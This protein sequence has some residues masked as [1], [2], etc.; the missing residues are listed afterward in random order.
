M[1]LC[2]AIAGNTCRYDRLKVVFV[3]RYFSFKKQ[4][5]GIKLS[6]IELLTFEYVP[7]LHS[8]AKKYEKFSSFGNA[9]GQEKN[10]KKMDQA[11]NMGIGGG[12][13]AGNSLIL[14]QKPVGIS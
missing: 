1:P 14:S 8:V 6:G 11:C 9:D 3:K 7:G 13:K 2:L 5:Q 10:R 12:V 4:S